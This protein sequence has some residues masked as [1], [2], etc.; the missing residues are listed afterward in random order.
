TDADKR[1]DELMK[2]NQYQVAKSDEASEV[3]TEK[4]SYEPIATGDT[5]LIHDDGFISEEKVQQL[6]AEKRENA[7][8]KMANDPRITK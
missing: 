4:S 8:F 3:K 7:F 2:K 6:K 5:V 1:V